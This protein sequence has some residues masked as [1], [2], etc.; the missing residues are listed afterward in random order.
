MGQRH[1]RVLGALEH[2]FELAGVY[3][4]RGDAECPAGVPRLSS[5][6]EAVSRA[7]VVFVATPIAGHAGLVARALGAG[8]HVLVEKPLCATATEARAVAGV[9][10]DG[11]RLFVGHSE[12]FNPVVRALARLLHGRGDEL[13]S[14]D[15]RRVGPTRPSD[16]GVLVNLG[17]HDLDLGAYLGGGP[18]AVRGALGDD[19]RADVLF[20]TA[21]GGVGHLHVDRGKPERRRT[22]EVLTARWLYEGDLLAKHLT[23]RPR[24]GGPC[25]DVPLPLEDPLTAQALAL[26]DALDGLGVREIASG[27]DGARA[28][29]A[30]EEAA[31][32]FRRKVVADACGLLPGS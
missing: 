24:A 1:L 31:A 22:I 21:G 25:T 3:D 8:R 19:E 2:R 4:I 6:A 30:A 17:V 27:V 10:R 23:R 18:I 12:R 13:L 26:A 9:A 28:V 15:L 14:M 16:H 29:E 7:E 5:E 20:S 32:A 11:A